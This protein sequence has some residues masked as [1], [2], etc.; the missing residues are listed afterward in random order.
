MP[1]REPM[2]LECTEC[3]TRYYRTTKTTSALKQ[4]QTLAL[5]AGVL[6]IRYKINSAWLIAIGAAAGL[7]K[8]ILR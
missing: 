1:A 8:I 6:L 4:G 5:V 7:L 2:F 3:G